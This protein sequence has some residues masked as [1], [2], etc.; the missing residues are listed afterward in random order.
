MKGQ[1][2]ARMFVR[3]CRLTKTNAHDIIIYYSVSSLNKLAD[4]QEGLWKN[5]FTQWE[6]WHMC[7]DVTTR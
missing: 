5:T 6:K 1:A 3:F 7:L 4:F 2:K